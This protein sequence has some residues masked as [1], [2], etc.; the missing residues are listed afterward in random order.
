M[1]S[2][3]SVLVLPTTHL[4]PAAPDWPAPPMPRDQVLLSLGLG[5]DSAY[6]LWRLI[7]DPIRHGLR[8]DLSNLTVVTAM[9]GDE[10]SDTIELANRFLLPLMAENGVRYVQL[11]RG[12]RRDSDGYLVLS[13]SRHP[14]RVEP[15]GPWKLSD[16]LRTSGTLPLFSAGKHLCSIK[17]KGWVI[18]RWAAENMAPGYR[19]ILGYDAGER[20]VKRAEKDRRFTTNGRRPWYPL[21]SWQMTRPDLLAELLRI[22]GVDWPKSYCVECPFPSVAASRDAHLE[23]ARRLPREA[24]MAACLEW[25][26]HALN[27]LTTLYSGTSLA[28]LLAEDGNTAALAAAE[29]QLESVKWSV[30]KVRRLLTA[31]RSAWC[32]DRHGPRCEACA[33]AGREVRCAACRA[34]ANQRCSPAE[35]TPRCTDATRKGTVWRSLERVG[36]PRSR[37]AASGMLHR[38][39][40]RQGLDVEVEEP[41]GV[42]R[43]WLL[44]RGSD[45]PAAEMF[46]VAVPDVVEEKAMPGFAALWEAHMARQRR[47]ATIAPASL[48]TD[49]GGRRMRRGPGGA[50]CWLR[51]RR[52]PDRRAYS[53]TDRQ[54]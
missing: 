40:V 7:T 32:M 15:A 5:A 10:W 30:F 36:L 50:A 17:Y 31:R 49:S 39:A 44:R 43:V 24:A 3:L 28:R 48:R 41:A 19:H 6:I 45:Y 51:H 53:H 2:A 22:F 37:A 29:E 47:V 16:E 11:A 27:P 21:I 9:T 4:R 12:G 35:R 54:A 8:P 1:S 23:R 52:H 34:L 14:Q 26:A 18:D 33:G 38:A 42:E 13:D 20:E 46:F 25:T